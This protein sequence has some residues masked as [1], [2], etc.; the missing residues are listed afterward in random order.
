[1]DHDGVSVQFGQLSEM[2]RAMAA[3]LPGSDSD[4]TLTMALMS[5]VPGL[6]TGGPPAALDEVLSDLR[7]NAV[8]LIDLSTASEGNNRT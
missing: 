5:V 8:A 2:V 1:M 4:A 6:A 3:A 7:A